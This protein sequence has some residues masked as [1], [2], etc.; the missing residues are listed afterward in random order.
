[1]KLV[2]LQLFLE[3]I[4]V[5]IH[6]DFEVRTF[7]WQKSCE[8][9]VVFDSSHFF[10]SDFELG[11][12]VSLES[13][14]KKAHLYLIP[15]FFLGK[16]PTKTIKFAFTVKHFNLVTQNLT[17][18]PPIRILL[19]KNFKI[20]PNILHKLFVTKTCKYQVIVTNFESKSQLFVSLKMNHI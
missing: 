3:V 20:G 5:I 17:R 11:N 1:M 12:R 16:L 18:V 8:G 6:W 19:R 9:C 4:K 10:V 14:E 2:E 15:R 13:Q 7:L